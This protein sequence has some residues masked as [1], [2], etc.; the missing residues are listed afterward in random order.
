V[1]TLPIV[2][3]LDVVERCGLGFLAGAKAELVDVFDL[4]GGEETFH[5]RVVEASGLCGRGCPLWCFD[6]SKR[7][8]SQ[9]PALAP[10]VSLRARPEGRRL[11]HQFT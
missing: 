3:D 8:V 4:E 6:C 5:R 9:R 2:E 7:T 1:K 10:G 11:V